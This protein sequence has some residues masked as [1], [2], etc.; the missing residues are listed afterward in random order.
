MNIA[1]R[2]Q[3]IVLTNDELEGHGLSGPAAVDEL[4]AIRVAVEAL[5]RAAQSQDQ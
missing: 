2:D 5:A 3:T 1:G 4:R